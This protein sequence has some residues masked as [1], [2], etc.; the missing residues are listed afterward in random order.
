LL[1]VIPASGDK[2]PL[3]L[4][5]VVQNQDFFSEPWVLHEYEDYMLYDVKRLDDGRIG[6][7]F[8]APSGME[9]RCVYDVETLSAVYMDVAVRKKAQ[10]EAM[11]RESVRVADAIKIAKSCAARTS[12]T[13]HLNYSIRG[14]DSLAW[15][16]IRVWDDGVKTYLQLKKGTTK[17]A[18]KGSEHPAL[19]VYEG[20]EKKGVMT[21]YRVKTDMY[22]ADRLFLRAELSI[23]EKSRERV[24]ITRL[25]GK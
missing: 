8:L 3:I 14:K 25:S 17:A 12:G 10:R 16:P 18:K 9:Y 15:K 2:A 5:K 23:G 24:V 13:L 1:L 21:E 4:E 11:L 22:V 7:V 20:K 19:T 6:V